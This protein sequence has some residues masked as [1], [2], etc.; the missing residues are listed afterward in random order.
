VGKP[1]IARAASRLAIL[2]AAIAT[3]AFPHGAEAAVT[4]VFGGDV[5]CATQPDGT[6]FCG[7]SSP[8]STTETFDGV[9]I[10]VN[11]GLPRA[12]TTGPDGPYP[13]VMLFHGYGGSKAGL[14]GM[15]RWL[16]HGYATFSMTERG[17]NQSCGTATA[18]AADPSGCAKGWIRLM[19]T[20]YEVRDAQFLAGRLVDEGLVQPTR[21][22]ATGGS[23]G[24]GKSM[25]LAALSDRVMLPNGSLAPW[26]SPKGTPMRLA[27]AAPIIPWTDLAYSLVPNGSTL[28][29]VADA[30]YRGRVGVQKQSLVNG[31]YLIGCALNFCAPPGADPDADLTSWKNRLDAGEP[32]DGDPLV[33]DVLDEVTSHHSSYYIDHSRPPAPL[34]IANGFTD[35]LFPADEALRYYNRTTTLY[36]GASI[37]LFFADIGHP[38]AQGKP[39]AQARLDALVDVLF[40]HYLK[41][42][43][44]RPASGVE[45]FTQ[46][47]PAGA[48]SGGPYRAANWDGIAPGEI[49]V[50]SGEPQTISASGGDA[51]VAQAFNPVG[52]GG[53]CARA[54]GADEQGTAN[55]RVHAA[56][57]GGYTLLGSSTVIAHFKLPGAN[58]QVAARL[59]DVAP[60]GQKTL[61]ARGLWRPKVSSHPIRQAFQLHANGWHFAQGHVAKLELL[62]DDASYGRA[63]NDQQDVRVHNLE[64]RLPVRQPPGSLGGLV[65]APA[66]EYVP[67]GYTLARGFTAR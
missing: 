3:L 47:C 62:A 35:D 56:P 60:D 36:P 49:R 54:A 32:Y 14:A 59:V 42:T 23:Y 10:D 1:G 17:F 67:D 64:L 57:A 44:P 39:D 45:A 53:A 6:R 34:L 13:L 46:T 7:S 21:I 66:A 22:A 27:A 31:L 4:S 26:T 30:P 48:P 19:D 5:S 41:G 51:A 61:V 33:T 28:D 24:G 65:K 52:G 8:R 55:Y 43:A 29:Y 58:S 11:L 9:P 25:A 50:H 20:R 12:P 16:D 15:Q 18:R 2:A 40:A 37:S 38:R 63:S